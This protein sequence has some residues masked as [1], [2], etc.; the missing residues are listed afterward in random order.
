MR[1]LLLAILV[2]F[3]GLALATDQA[4]AQERFGGLTGSVTDESGGVLPGATVNITNKGTGQVRSVVSG[5]DGRYAVLDLDPAG[6]RFV[7]SSRDF[8]PCMRKI[9]A[10]CSAGRST[11]TLS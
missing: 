2:M 11:S 1:K 9:S 3:V 5:S 10:S 7:S 8:R 4:L 6:T